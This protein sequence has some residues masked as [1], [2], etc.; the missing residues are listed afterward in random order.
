M[1][2]SNLYHPDHAAINHAKAV[3]W[4]TFVPLLVHSPIHFTPRLEKPSSAKIINMKK[5]LVILGVVTPLL[6]V[7]SHL[8]VFFTRLEWYKIAPLLVF[9]YPALAVLLYFLIDSFESD[10]STRIEYLFLFI[11]LYCVGLSTAIVL[12]KGL[13]GGKNPI[14]RRRQKISKDSSL[15]GTPVE[16]GSPCNKEVCENTAC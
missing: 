7:V 6:G 14:I 13:Y 1:V 5:E 11:A 8:A 16:S 4:E 10:L 2:Q 3:L 9:V 12:V 15:P